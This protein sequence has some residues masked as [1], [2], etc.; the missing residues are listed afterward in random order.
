MAEDRRPNPDELL[1]QVVKEEEKRSR[2]KLK[3]FLGYSAGV[4]KTYAMLED[5]HRRQDRGTDVAV[6]LLESHGRKET[7]ALLAGLE[8]VPPRGAEHRGLQ[9]KE[10]DIDAVIARRPELALVDE[11]AHTNA[12]GSRHLK[13]YQD[14]QELLEAGIDV[15]TTLNIQHLDSMNDAVAQITGVKVHETI[16]DSVLDGANEIK[17]VDIPPNELM[18]RFWEGKVYI[19]SQAAIAVENF[20]TEGNLIALREMTFRRAA[21]HVDEQMLEYM[22]MRSIPGPWPASET[23][24][25]CIGNSRAL[26]ERLVRTARRLADEL[27]AEWYAIYVETP[28]HSRFSRKDRMEAMRGLEIAAEMGAKTATSFGVSIAEEVV[29]FARKN[30]VIRIIVGRPPRPRWQELIL[31][32]VA[33]QIVSLS[34]PIDVLVITGEGE[35]ERKGGEREARPKQPSVKNRYFYCT[36]LVMIVTIIAYFLKPY[37]SPTNLVM[38]YLIGVVVAAVTWGLWKA[39]FTATLSVLMFDF[40]FVAPHFSLRII[41]TEYLVTFAAFLFVGVVISLLVVRSRDNAA[42]AQ[43]REEY[44]SALYALSIDLASANDIERAL[45]TVSG[46]VKRSCNCL[47]AYLLPY[48]SCLGV[49]FSDSGLDLDEKEMT[50]ADWTYRNGQASGKDTDTLSSAV[51]KF[52]PLRTPSGVVGVMG[53]KP[54]ERDGI[55]RLEQ[56]RLIEAFTSQTALA[57]ER[58]H[59]WNQ[60]SRSGK[61]AEGHEA[62]GSQAQ[63]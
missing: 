58:I 10:P 46:H 13:R 56:E 39:V 51:L 57:I 4:G 21:D 42:A 63:K 29:R 27:R 59:F 7:E 23:L 19:P 11:F 8:V 61:Q 33:N 3:V 22:K 26:N 15:Y 38:F 5:A 9:L 30:N 35:K 44:T 25:V 2:G 62:T 49:V 37:L 55:I 40:F 31:G 32:S 24:L 36:W 54:E 6:A 52:Y 50:A 34:G 48:G 53:I 45:E 12:P 1:Q 16:P 17:I 20:F 41:D 60:L 18:Q 47:S 14:V 28:A 43:R